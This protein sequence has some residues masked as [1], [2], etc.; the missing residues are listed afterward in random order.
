MKEKQRD[1]DGSDPR[2]AKAETD[3]FTPLAERRKSRWGGL[4]GGGD[5]VVE[6][7]SPTASDDRDDT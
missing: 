3:P 5:D 7:N 6:D 4:R 1:R 2:S